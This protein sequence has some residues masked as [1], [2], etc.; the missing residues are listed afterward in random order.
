MSSQPHPQGPLAVERIAPIFE[1]LPDEL[2]IQCSHDSGW[3]TLLYRGEP[4]ARYLPVHEIAELSLYLI[5]DKNRGIDGEP[6][7]VTESIVRSLSL[8]KEYGFEICRE[9]AEPFVNGRFR[10]SLVLRNSPVTEEQVLEL[11]PMVL[12]ASRYAIDM[13]ADQDT[14]EKPS[15]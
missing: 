9:Y 7:D 1:E 3:L 6:D 11:A 13:T 8:L 5:V 12:D 15:D 4:V 14:V 10:Q 2:D